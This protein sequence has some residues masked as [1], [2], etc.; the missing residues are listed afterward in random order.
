MTQFHVYIDGEPTKG[1]FDT[2]QAAKE[3]YNEE[4]RAGR[5]VEIMTVNSPSP[6]ITW[7]Y[8]S[9]IDDWVHKN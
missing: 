7:Y 5:N 9:S 1:V 3:G 2:L 6:V 8:D 4:A